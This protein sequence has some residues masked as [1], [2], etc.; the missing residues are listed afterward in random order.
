MKGW[1]GAYLVRMP[2][3]AVSLLVGLVL[4][5]CGAGSPEADEAGATPTAQPEPPTQPAAVTSLAGQRTACPAY[6]ADFDLVRGTAVVAVPAMEE[7][8]ARQWFRDP[9]FGTCLVRVTDRG[10]DLAPD[11]TSTGMVNEYARVDSFNADG[12]WLLVRGTDGTWYLYDAQSFQPLGPVALAAEPRWDAQDPDLVYFTDETSLLSLDVESEEVTTVHDFAGDFPG[13]SLAAVW[14]RYEGRPSHD[15]RFW[16]L[17]A[18]DSDWEPV[19]FVVYDRQ[20]DEVTTRDLRGMPGVAE[21]IDHV[22]ISPLG[23]YFLASFDRYCD[24]GQLG[25]DGDPCGLM[26]YGRDLASG[27]GLLR[28]IGHYDV[29]LDGEGREVVIYQDIDTDEIA[30]LDLASGAVTPLW[31]IDFRYTAIGLHFSGLAYDR[32]GWAVVSTHDNDPATHTW[33][34]D[35]VFLVELMAG[36]RVVRLAHTHSV[37]EDEEALDYWAEPHASTNRDLTR[38]VF[39]TNWGR[40]GTGEVEMYLMALPPDWSVPR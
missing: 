13:Q 34:D 29:A 36:G 1:W 14:T 38:I 8:P 37:V 23:T 18:E 6:P 26:V 31:T 40:S 2:W 25:S 32:P 28:I 39:S 11:D 12:S 10:Q 35:Q 7:P 24:H 27:R 33:M 3:L 9:A 17:M 19:A 22:T 5:A 4:V 20:R 15:S 21:G 16:G 30:M